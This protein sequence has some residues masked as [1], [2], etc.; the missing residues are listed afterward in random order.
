MAKYLSF[1]KIILSLI[2]GF[3]TAYSQNLSVASFSRFGFGSRGISMGNA[4]SAVTQ[5]EVVGYYNP[6]VLPFAAIRKASLTVGFLSL[7]RQLDFFHYTQSLY[8]TAGFSLF[9]IRSG[10]KN[11]ES[12]DVD[13]YYIENLNTAEYL[14]GFSFSNKIIDRLSVG[15]SLKLYYNRLYRELKSQ[16]LGIDFGILF[17]IT[18]NI[19]LSASIHDLNAK[20]KWDSSPIY[21]EK[22]RTVVE[23]FPLTRKFGISY[24]FKNIFLLSVDF[25]KVGNEEKIN[26]GSEVFPLYFLSEQ[27]KQMK[28]SFCIRSGLEIF[29]YPRFSIG[30]GIK[31]KISRFMLSLDYAYKFERYSPSGI[32]MLTLGLEI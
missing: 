13:G 24:V 16:T 1:S 26:F 6:A 19:S 25:S 14:L 7:D 27:F 23:N 10:V 22:G 30:A 5:G 17:K 28:N 3:T 2:L 31:R 21:R 15:I 12:R 29:D 8:P 11:I 32:Q 4:M 9:L 18:E 20:Y